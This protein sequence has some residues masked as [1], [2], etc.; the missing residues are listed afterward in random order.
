MKHFYLKFNHGVEIGARLAYIGHYKRT[1]D[2]NILAIANDELKHQIALGLLLKI[3]GEKPSGVIDGF[4]YVVGSSI[5]FLCK[6]LPK[7]LL[8]FVASSMEVFAIF[9]YKRLAKQYVN[10]NI[11]FLNMAKRE[12]EHKAY[13]KGVSIG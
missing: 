4:F 13:F 1:K 11:T 9:S 3:L 12:L 5:S 2:P 6:F 10:H 8:N 7:P